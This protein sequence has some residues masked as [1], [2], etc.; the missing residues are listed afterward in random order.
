MNN[1]T[2]LREM[3]KL[4]SDANNPIQNGL[5]LTNFLNH[6]FGFIDRKINNFE[7]Q[8]LKYVMFLCEEQM[9]KE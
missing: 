6:F 2:T 7:K 3:V 4:V 1:V 5:V 9:R 8:N